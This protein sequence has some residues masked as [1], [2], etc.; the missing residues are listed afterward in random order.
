MRSD[1]PDRG[2]TQIPAFT[3]MQKFLLAVEAINAE[4]SFEAVFGFK[5]CT[6]THKNTKR[7]TK[8]FKY[9]LFFEEPNPLRF[10]YNPLVCPCLLLLALLRQPALL[11]I[12]SKKEKKKMVLNT[13]KSKYLNYWAW[14]YVSNAW[15]FHGRVW[16]KWKKL[17]Q[18][19]RP[20]IK[21][22][23]LME[24]NSK[25]APIILVARFVAD[26]QESQRRQW[27]LITRHVTTRQV[28]ENCCR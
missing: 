7:E 18:Q 3:P 20:R 26:C 16:K 6:S 14:G 19:T 25:V 27:V 9:P 11:F 4:R 2:T 1:L 12:I 13:Q 28:I 15:F 17:L 5:S 23:L 22:V 21:L 8:K 10:N 24:N